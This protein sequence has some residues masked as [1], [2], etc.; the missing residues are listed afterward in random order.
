MKISNLLARASLVIAT[1]ALL[2]P[3]MNSTADATKPGGGNPP[4]PASP[5]ITALASSNRSLAVTWSESSAGSITFVATAKSA[6][7]S[8]KSCTSHA[9]SCAISSL[10]NGVIYNVS[11]VASN[12]GGSSVPS[13]V[14]TQI[15]GIPGAP[16]SVHTVAATASATISWA[17]PKASGV[18]AVSSY[19][20]TASP[21]GFSC[22]SQGTL[23]NSPLRSCQI[24]G[25]T[26]G[27]KYTVTVTATNAYGTGV[28][29][30]E[31]S[32][33]AN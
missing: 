4:A 33:T 14:A 10:V 13:A 20:A 32:V 6:G 25:L 29:S 31:A 24:P 9:T 28:P 22:S 3:L 27:T 17:P 16:L 15:V 2:V 30:K 19:M 21:G 11:V 12:T 5:A 1:T 7:K 23:L 26:S 8:S 18:A